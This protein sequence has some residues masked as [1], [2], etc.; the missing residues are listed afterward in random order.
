MFSIKRR[1]C[2]ADTDAGGITYHS[3]YLDF[4]EQARLE[5][6]IERGITQRILWH[7]YSMMMVLRSCDIKYLRPTHAEDLLTVTVEDVVVKLDNTNNKPISGNLKMEFNS[8]SSCIKASCLISGKSVM[9][10]K[11]FV[12][13]KRYEEAMSILICAL[14]EAHN[15]MSSKLF[16]AAK[17]NVSNSEIFHSTIYGDGRIAFAD[18]FSDAL[19]TMS[20][21]FDVEDALSIQIKTITSETIKPFL[22]IHHKIEKINKRFSA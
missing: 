18:S 3:K 5:F 2:F 11:I 20:K 14:M 13:E 12:T 9:E 22:R 19:K 7:D 16:F 10:Y 21:L 4:C 1:V 17:G 15:A 8:E 6:L